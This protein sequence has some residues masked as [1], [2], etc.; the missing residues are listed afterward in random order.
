MANYVMKYFN[1][2]VK[3]ILAMDKYLASEVK[4]AYV[5]GNSRI[6]GVYIPADMILSNIIENLNLG[7]KKTWINRFRKRNS[8]K[9]LFESI[10]YGEK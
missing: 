5:V 6:K 3:Q 7:Y 9:D 1:L 2:L 10:I 8:G 4:I